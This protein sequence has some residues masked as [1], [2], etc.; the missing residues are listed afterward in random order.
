MA[1]ARW[2]LCSRA[3]TGNLLDEPERNGRFDD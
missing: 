2:R 3:L 1:V